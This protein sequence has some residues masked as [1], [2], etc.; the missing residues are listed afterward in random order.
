MELKQQFK[1]S[2]QLVMTPQLQQAIKLLQLSRM[3][4]SDLIMQEI[5]EN[6]VLDESSEAEG[7]EKDRREE[8]SDNP[9]ETESDLPEA[10]TDFDWQNYVD[11]SS[12][13]ST[14]GSLG[15]EEREWS[16]PVITRKTSFA[17]HLLWQL[18]LNDLSDKEMEAGEYI[19]GNLDKDGYLQTTVEEIALNT[20]ADKELVEDIRNKIQMFDPVGVA[21]L[22]LNE[23]LLAQAEVLPGDNSLVKKILLNHFRDLERKK[24][25]A[26]SKSLR[27]SLKE[28]IAAC[29]II[30]NMEPRPGRAFNDNEPQYITPDIYVYKFDDEYVVALNEDGQP[31]LRIN[32]FYKNFYLQY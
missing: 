4:L 28:I 20:G 26:I 3:E 8:R 12:K 13:P 14:G 27:V 11:R 19:I 6:P 5:N 16:E 32:T 23:C 9:A 15:G 17:D 18:R 10:K 31:R 2:Q 24:Y 25:Q 30:T 7:S 22:N 29:E 1:L 21:S